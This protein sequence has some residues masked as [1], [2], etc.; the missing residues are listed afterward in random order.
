MTETTDVPRERFRLTDGDQYV[1][2]GSELFPACGAGKKAKGA[3]KRSSGAGAPPCRGAGRK[4]GGRA[5]G[6]EPADVSAS[7]EKPAEYVALEGL[8]REKGHV[9]AGDV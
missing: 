8:L 6:R 5:T 2:A 7:A 9:T 4:R 1:W 3:A